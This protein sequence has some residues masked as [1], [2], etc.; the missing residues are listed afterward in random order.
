MNYLDKA[1]RTMVVKCLTE[2][3]SI[4]ATSRLTGVSITTVLKLLADLGKVCAD[5]QD[6]VLR[7]LPCRRVEVDEIWAFVGAKEKNATADQKAEGWGDIWTWTAFCP[8]TKLIASWYVGDRSATSAH[9]F[10]SDMATRL[11]HRIQLTSDGHK[12]YLQAVEDAFG[13]EIDYAMLI[14]QYG[15]EGGREAPANIKYSPADCTGIKVERISGRPDRKHISTSGVER[16]NLTIR[17]S[18]RRFTRLTNGF[19]KKA[20]NHAHALAIYFMN[21][22]FCRVHQSLRMSPAMAAGVSKVLWEV[23]DVVALL[24]KVEQ[25][26]E[27]ALGPR[28]TRG[29]KV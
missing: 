12:P 15:N 3:M 27:A 6:E 25:E 8:D 16:Q 14:K 7:N 22:N 9:Y 17:M 13:G 11:S 26:R 23:E 5:Y 21:Y 28:R 1:K 29:T 4:R 2:G 24:D 20:E 10:I 18:N 19:S